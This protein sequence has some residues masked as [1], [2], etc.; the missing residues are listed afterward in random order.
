ML[1]QQWIL[2]FCASVCRSAPFSFRRRFQNFQ[3]DA[4]E[5]IQVIIHDWLIHSFLWWPLKQP[6]NNNN[7]CTKRVFLVTQNSKFQLTHWKAS[8][9]AQNRNLFVFEVHIHQIDVL[10][11]KS[12]LGSVGCSTAEQKGHSEGDAFESHV[13]RE[14]FIMTHVVDTHWNQSIIWAPIYIAMKSRLHNWWNAMIDLLLF[15]HL[16][17]NTLP[18]S[19]VF[20]FMDEKYKKK[21]QQNT[22]NNTVHRRRMYWQ[23]QFT[24]VIAFKW[25]N[26]VVNW[27]NHFVYQFPFRIPFVMLVDFSI[28][29]HVSR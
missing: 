23:M 6:V 26:F 8:D 19:F 14:W 7:T 11:N 20:H 12:I 16:H 4:I 25:N 2:G 9:F 17:T 15:W 27:F 13:N 10:T 21:K 1:Y 24:D 18:V 28:V 22:T 5:M 29:L 3:C